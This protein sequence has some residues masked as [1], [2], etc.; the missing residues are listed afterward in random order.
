MPSKPRT[1]IA[2]LQKSGVNL[3]AAAAAACPH[4]LMLEEAGRVVYANPAYARL[5]GA[6]SPAQVLGKAVSQLPHPG[7]VPLPP[8]RKRRSANNHDEASAPE[9]QTTRWPFRAQGWP[10]AISVVRDVAERHRLEKQLHDSQKM[11]AVG[12]LV[13]GVAHDFNNL[14]TAITLY[15]DLLLEAVR[16][17]GPKRQAQEIRGAAQRGAQLVR[18][19][20]A[21][22]RQQPLA[23]RVVSL[24]AVLAGMCDMLERLIGEDIELELRCQE[25]LGAVRVDT[26]QIQQAVLN[27]VMNARDAMPEGG[28][29][30]IETHN[31]QLAR[32]AARRHG[33]GAG[34]YV[35]LT[36]SDTGCGMDEHVRARLFE[37]FFTTKRMGEGTGLGL[38]MVYGFV[39]QSGGA[40]SVASKPQRGTRVS[41]LLPL[42]PA[43]PEPLHAEPRPSRAGTPRQE[44]VLVVEDDPAVRSSVAQLLREG[45]YRVLEAADGSQ[46]LRLA[47]ESAGHIDL[48]LTDVVMPGGC[49]CDVARS[50]RARQPDLRVLFISGYPAAATAAAADAV[51]LYKPFSHRT[52]L[53][54]V[55]EV[56]DTPLPA[57]V[58]VSETVRGDHAC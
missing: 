20:L 29:L 19:L 25:P 36:V 8:R 2:T 54:K 9:Y 6:R 48:L 15:S 30:T 40:V 11:E 32:R 58:A 17:A 56:L 51:L 4:G 52:L 33:L 3:L 41:V 38:A 31:R 42:C 53:G 21:F 39:T 43:V 26:G 22:T 18:Q 12:R 34:P 35:M 23:P 37:P 45:G 16:E 44:T 50:L 27:L 28:R 7:S 10:L 5:V 49:G 55:R 57:L 24:N 13:G 14:L 46:A 47:R 1:D